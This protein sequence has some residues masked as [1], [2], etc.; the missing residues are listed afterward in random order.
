MEQVTISRD[1]AA[2][3]LQVLKEVAFPT[4]QGKIAAGNAQMELEIGLM[5][6]QQNGVNVPARVEEAVGD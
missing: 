2:L 6:L 4:S 3:C 5:A 1:A